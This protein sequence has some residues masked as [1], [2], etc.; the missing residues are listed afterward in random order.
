MSTITRTEFF[1]SMITADVATFAFEHLRDNIQWEEGVRSKMGFTRLAKSLS[2]HDDDIVR[3]LIESAVK[4]ISNGKNKINGM[5]IFG[6]YL[7]YYKDKTFWTPNHSHK[8]TTQII[9]SLGGL[10]I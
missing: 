5:A 10:L 9:I 1:P 3:Q 6:I 8:G 4:G 2:T 7:N